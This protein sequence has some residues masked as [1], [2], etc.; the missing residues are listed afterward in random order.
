MIKAQRIYIEADF[1]KGFP[2]RYDWFYECSICGDVLPSL[3]VDNG[4]CSCGNIFIDIDS[5][6]LAVREP[7]K[8]RLFSYGLM[9]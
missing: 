3:P 9:P 4:G 2:T 8:I 6:R 5:G 1:L 7:D